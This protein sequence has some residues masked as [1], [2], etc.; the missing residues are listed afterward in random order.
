MNKNAQTEIIGVAIIVVIV[1]LGGLFML[2]SR[3]TTSTDS[4]SDQKLA[5]SFLNTLMNTK[6]EK[7]KIV[8]DIIQ[9]C[10]RDDCGGY[11]CCTYVYKAINNALEKTLDTYNYRLTIN[12]AKI[13]NPIFNDV[14]CTEESEQDQ[15]GYYYIPSTPPL[16][17]TLRICK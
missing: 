6:T 14:T 13:P 15:P 12:T 1:V 8:S 10:N 7:N 2:G 11:D 17:V 16:Q 4:Y 3:K 9:D 5:Q